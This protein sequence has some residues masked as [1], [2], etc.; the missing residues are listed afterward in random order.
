[1]TA[2]NP[3]E[4]WRDD[5]PLDYAYDNPD[6]PSQVTLFDPAPAVDLKTHWLSADIETV[7]PA[8]EWR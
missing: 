8:G 1:M 6:D 3:P 2:A 4:Q 5:P 7:I